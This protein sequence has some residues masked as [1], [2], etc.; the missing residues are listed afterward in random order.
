MP[1][2]SWSGATVFDYNIIDVVYLINDP[3]KSLAVMMSDGTSNHLIRFIS[4]LDC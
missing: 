2:T 4:Y 3:K 1:I